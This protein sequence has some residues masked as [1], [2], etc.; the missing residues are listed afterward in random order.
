MVR[1]EKLEHGVVQ[2]DVRIIMPA[3]LLYRCDVHVVLLRGVEHVGEVI[4]LAVAAGE[5][6]IPFTVFPEILSL[7]V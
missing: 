2:N 6:E 3:C 1:G 7:R 4:L 5:P